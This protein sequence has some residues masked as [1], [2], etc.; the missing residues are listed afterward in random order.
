MSHRADNAPKLDAFVSVVAVI[1]DE[2]T[3]LTV[4]VRD[5][6]DVLT[7]HYTNFEVVLVGNGLNSGQ[8]IE[9]RGVLK[10]V[11]CVR[12][13]RLSRSF[14]YDT[15]IFSGL[16]SAI[17]DY[18][19]V[20]EAGRDPA[21]LIPTLVAPLIAGADIVQGMSTVAPGGSLFQRT[22][23]RLFYWYNK[24]ALDVV[25]PDRA[26]YLTAFSRRAVNSLSSSNREFKYLRHLMRHVGYS[27]VEVPYTPSASHGR[28]RGLR[29][30]LRDATE[31]ITSYSIRPLRVVSLAGL[32]VAGVNLAYALYVVVVFLADNAV[33]RGWTTTNL[34]LS[35]MFFFLFVSLAVLSE[36]IGRLLAESR[37]EPTYFIMEELMSER[38]IAD[39]TRRNIA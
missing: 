25:M 16:D 18:V 31:M 29:T 33:E 4:L 21:S 36:Y 5:Y 37:R 28:V 34:Q 9:L 38:L 15:A 39:E 17:G 35:I 14:A 8:L 13:L 23:R 30:G 22:G 1:D 12:V 7:A 11:P 24:T 2:T 10:D 19:V 32:I 26:T 27:I 3:D 20:S 6:V